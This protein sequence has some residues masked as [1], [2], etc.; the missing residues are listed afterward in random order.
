MNNELIIIRINWNSA[1]SIKLNNHNLRK[2]IK[3][4]IMKDVDGKNI[5]NI[6]NIQIFRNLLIIVEWWNSIKNNRKLQIA[7]K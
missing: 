7:R 1:L 4:I 2:M 5:F 6:K 3:F